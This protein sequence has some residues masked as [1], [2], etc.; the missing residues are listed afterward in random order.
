M[1]R[2]GTLTENR[3]TVVKGWF[4]GV[5]IDHTPAAD[6]LRPALL[7]ELQL[8][9][10]LNSKA[11]LIEEPGKPVEFVGNRTECAMLML[12][13]TWGVGYQALR[14]QYANRLEKVRFSPRPASA[15]IMSTSMCR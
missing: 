2:A 14:D 4:G 13:K 15:C 11:F 8:N 6:E 5:T 7:T 9:M 3:M 10:A 12:L 1:L